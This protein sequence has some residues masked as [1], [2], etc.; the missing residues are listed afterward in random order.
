M[1]EH[2]ISEHLE[3]YIIAD[4][5]SRQ[6]ELAPGFKQ[7]IAAAH[8]GVLATWVGR[9]SRAKLL[10]AAGFEV[11][12]CKE[13]HKACDAHGPTLSIIKADG[14][15]AGI[16]TPVPWGSSEQFR[17]DPTCR[18]FVFSLVNRRGDA[19]YYVKQVSSA[20]SVVFHDRDWVASTG[21]DVMGVNDDGELICDADFGAETWGLG[22]DPECGLM[23]S[24][25]FRA[26]L[27]RIETWLWP[28]RDMPD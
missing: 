24:G 11:F 22:H 1:R 9:N 4:T 13:W 6:A 23:G 20:A 28:L 19:P 3:E 12:S 26:R 21:D 17:S 5:Y 7:S 10:Y 27:D 25:E 18:T 15:V 16:Y 8:E 2:F 14:C